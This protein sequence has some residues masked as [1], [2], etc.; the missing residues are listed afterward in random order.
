MIDI[1]I[2][3]MDELKK[4]MLSIAR[5]MGA[6][7]VERVNYAAADIITQEVKIRAPQGPTGN[8]KDSPVTK[9]L[10]REYY[11]HPARA[12][13]AIDRKKA[14]HAH[15]V[16]HGTS[17]RRRPKNA[18]VLADKKSGKFYGQEVGPMPANPFFHMAV[19]SKY[20]EAFSFLKNGLGD[21]IDR[22]A[23]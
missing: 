18:K 21:L 7:N 16:E 14:P 6:D 1:K 19:E 8:L 4:Q 22:G 13:S 2:E 5:S 10:K 17:K 9:A 23:R 15:L 3:G 11:G 12:I 20:N